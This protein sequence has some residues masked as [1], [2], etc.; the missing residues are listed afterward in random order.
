MYKIFLLVLAS[1]F[2][3]NTFAAD[4][5][6]KFYIAADLGTVAYQ[7]ATVRI[8]GTLNTFPNPGA[9][10]IAGGYYFTPIAAAEIGYAS[11]GKSILK[12]TSGD[13]TLEAKSITFAAR[14]NHEI[15]SQTQLFGKIGLAANSYTEKTSGTLVFADGSTSFSGSESSLMYGF[16]L[17]YA[18]TDSVSLQ[19]QY[20]NYGKFASTGASATSFSFG[21]A[22]NF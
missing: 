8:N 18:T 1:L 13:V 14:V 6:G 20:I 15:A 3:L 21:I 16:G 2:S 22:Y 4:Q 12:G 19:A 10:I 9:L 7:D 17:S 11:A 5:K